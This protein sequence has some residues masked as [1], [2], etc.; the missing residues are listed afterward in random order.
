MKSKMNIGE[1]IAFELVEETERNE[2][3]F[4]SKGKDY[5]DVQDG[6]I[7]IANKDN[8]L[9]IVKP[10]TSERFRDSKGHFV[11]PI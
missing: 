9:C 5:W 2:Y 4:T 8:Q 11:K 3:I 6:E 1:A 7:P 10:I